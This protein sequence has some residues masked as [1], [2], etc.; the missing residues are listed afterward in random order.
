MRAAVV[1]IAVCLAIAGTGS[2]GNAAY[3]GENG[4]IAFTRL[5]G[6]A[7][8]VMAVNAD[9]AGLDGLTEGDSFNCCASWSADGT[10]LAFFSNRSGNNDVWVMNSD[11][12][13]LRNVTDHPADEGRASLSPDGKRIAFGSDRDGD[14]EIFVANA[15]GTGVAQLTFNNDFNDYNPAW[16]PDGSLIAF[17]TNRDGNQEIYTM[18]AAGAAQTNLTND[19]AEDGEPD[20]SPDGKRIAFHSTR[21]G[22]FDIYAMDGN[23]SSAE[24]LA[25]DLA[26]DK[27]PA[28]S[29]DGT[30]VAF[31]STRGDGTS[32]IWLAPVSG[33]N[34]T[35]VTDGGGGMDSDPDWQPRL[36]LH[37]DTDCD[38][39]IDSVDGLNVLRDTAGF[40]PSLCINAGDAD[41]DDDRDSVDGLGL[42]RH[43][44]A[45]PPLET[46]PGC[47]DIGEPL[48]P[49]AGGVVAT[50]MV[51]DET[52]SAWVRN[53]E[54][55]Q[56]LFDLE[57]GESIASI[58]VGPVVAGAGRGAHNAPWSWHL[59]PDAITMAEATI[60]L[61]D[62][63]PSDVESDLDYWINTVGQY[64]P[65]GAD[66]VELRDYR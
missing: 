56:Q 23:G 17:E 63:R 25:T 47:P 7:A 28:W 14:F 38:G 61:C 9:G 8:H 24:L 62:G 10:E 2:A 21:S 39:D 43:V 29:P 34:A 32:R 1:A 6:G 5:A 55:I 20:W 44:A 16:S 18:S 41:C 33:G 60:E 15:D 65:W 22:N 35:M 53:P 54:T 40:P 12:S 37:G 42:L 46:P 13:G 49:L 11:G 51:V 52:F 57:A 3:P 59:D 26:S 30:T 50:F 58:P 64:C 31:A 66:L 36:P 48:A 27:S 19:P 4:R 45:L